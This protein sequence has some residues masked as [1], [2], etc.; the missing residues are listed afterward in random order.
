MQN[1]D[2][3]LRPGAIG[4]PRKGETEQRRSHL[5]SVATTLFVEKGYYRVSLAMIAQEAR[6]AVRTHL[7]RFWG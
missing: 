2:N 5:I 6:V 3:C 7:P 4:R 1:N